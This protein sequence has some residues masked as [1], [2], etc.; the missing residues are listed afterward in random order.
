MHNSLPHDSRIFSAVFKEN[1][2]DGPIHL[3]MD[4]LPDGEYRI[5]KDKIFENIPYGRGR[6]LTLASPNNNFVHVLAPKNF[7]LP[8]KNISG[9]KLK[10]LTINKTGGSS[11]NPRFNE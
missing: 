6:Q 9:M 2:L 1:A 7:S 11:T 10:K 5:E 3:S 8:T 4:S